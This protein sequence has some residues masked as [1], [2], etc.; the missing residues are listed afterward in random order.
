MARLTEDSTWL[1]QQIAGL[2]ILYQEGSEDEIVQF[3]PR[4]SNATAQAQGVIWQSDRL[5][6]EEKSFASFWSGYFYAH[7]VHAA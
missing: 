2:V 5:T 4:D 7:V 1:I 6:D 3:D